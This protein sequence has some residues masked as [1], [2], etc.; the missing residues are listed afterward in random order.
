MERPVPSPVE[1]LVRPRAIAIVGASSDPRKT[2]GKP[3]VYLRKHGFG[4][5]IY[6]VNPNATEI[7]G[8]PCYPSV[9]ALPSAPDVGL[10]LVGPRLVVPAL[11]ELAQLGTAAAIV[12][13][14]GYAEV[15]EQ[16]AH[17]QEE[18]RDAAGPMRLLGPNTI[19]LLNLTDHT[20]ISP[21]VSLE[22][23][24]LPI[25]RVGLV[26][27]S[28]GIVGSLLSRAS[29]RGIG[30]SR[31]VSTGN[32]AD[33]EV[34]DLVEYLID[35]D[36]T[37]V[38]ALYLE[39]LRNPTRFRAA[40]QRAAT[41]GKPLVAF[42]VGRSE[43]GARSASSHTAAL[44]GAD[45]VYDAF[46]EQCGI[47]RVTTF[48]ELLDV[49]AA[50]VSGKM[51][52]GNRLGILTSTG[53]GGVL[54]ADACGLAGFETPPPDAATATRLGE[55]LVGEGSVPDRNP[56]DLT[57][58]GLKSEV[59]TATITALLN[60]PRYD[61]VIVVIGSS[62]L[63]EPNLAADPIIECAGRTSKP[64]MAYL[65]PSA[66]PVVR[67]L[68]RHG[69]PAFEAPESCAAALSALR[70]RPARPSGAEAI[71]SVAPSRPAG[72]F[73][74]I[75]P[76]R[77]NEADSK[78]LFARYGIPVARELVATD[79][80]A[81]ARAAETLG[82]PVVLK[83]LSRDIAHKTELGGVLLDIE[84]AKVAERAAAMLAA[85]R[86]RSP[87]ATIEGIVVQERV[88]GGVEMIVGFT[89]DPQFG[90]AILVGAGGIAAEIFEDTVLR[91]P[92]IAPADAAEMLTRLR[93][94]P[95]LTGFRGRPTCDIKALTAAIVAFASMVEHLGDRMVEAEIN[96]LMVL[97]RGQGVRA[98]DGVAVFR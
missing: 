35:D 89:R 26:S 27:Q 34:S 38:I 30:F 94:Y 74:G 59:Y 10:V 96:P 86:Q 92:P 67:N 56:I 25:G 62:A 75:A 21:S 58:A 71:R 72:L 22:V 64:L 87:S 13:A 77:L 19:G 50:L 5:T 83:V 31:M 1:R 47:M 60:S 28:G 52:A 66:P 80:Q 14:G 36:A 16:G 63:G 65:S 29:A 88:R 43:P 69:V 49:S 84:P 18:L 23:D 91:L 24:E 95:L 7:D 39:G 45:R 15:G 55:A 70:R 42:K 17:R 12:L 33:L 44:A 81:A 57:L 85:V 79:P 9:Q 2:A 76:G 32:E 11:R 93:S 82:G 8:L 73:D 98:V 90:P 46:F 78:R 68:N 40:A 20:V 53:G 97:P 6:L 41:R 4:G 61:A 3:S 54:V 48:S 37:D 51:L